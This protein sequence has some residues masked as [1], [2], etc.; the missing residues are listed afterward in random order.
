MSFNIQVNSLEDVLSLEEDDSSFVL[1]FMDGWLE[2][3][4]AGRCFGVLVWHPISI[5]DL[6]F[7]SGMLDRFFAIDLM[8]LKFHLASAKDCDGSPSVI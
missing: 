3:T 5:E 4:P 2:G 8:I 6:S 7:G 1:K